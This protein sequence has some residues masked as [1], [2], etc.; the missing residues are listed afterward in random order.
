MRAPEQ[1]GR[2]RILGEL[3]R[4]AMGTVYRARDLGLEREV[5]LKVMTRGAADE[6]ARARFLREARAAA[7]LQHPNIVVIYE[8]GEHAGAPF[9]A[10][11]LLEGVDLQHAIEAGLRPD[12]RTTLPIMLQV[13]AGL[14]HAHDHG[15]VHRDIKP[16]NVF[17]P[18][19]RPAKIMDFGVARLGGTTTTTSG[20]VTG[21]PSYMSP[22]QVAGDEIDG[23]SDLFSVGLILFELVTGEKAIQAE[24]IVST[25]YK[26][27][28]E[29]PDLALLPQ[30]TEWRRLRDV[31]ARALA[32]SREQRYPDARSMSAELLQALGDFGGVPDW[33]APA[34]QALVP[35]RRRPVA[36][37]GGSASPAA[38]RPPMRP[39]TVPSG[40]KAARRWRLAGAALAALATLAAGAWWLRS[41]GVGPA[42]T[43]PSPLV[44]APPSVDAAPAS[45]SPQASSPQRPSP[46]PSA[47]AG[48]SPT[49]SASASAE[50]S[51]SPAEATEASAPSPSVP[52]GGSAEARLAR[53]RQ[54]LE[55][56][57]WAEALAEARAVLEGAPTNAEAASLAQ[58]AEAELVLEDCLRKA[59]A[60]I[61][62]GDRDRALEELRRGFL[63]RSNDPRLLELH[64]QAVQQ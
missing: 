33:T 63:V 16:S 9:M 41:P 54:A 18:V 51:A 49:S 31:L 8:L 23:R 62:A 48:P 24:S 47:D 40:P 26:V 44:P 6:A 58:L 14:A 13:L 30:G 17:L 32:R 39:P 52:G 59:R 53:A 50:T 61:Q 15:V 38:L 11:E 34:D 1:I 29:G 12:P 36:A 43:Q 10:L 45:P 57:G 2:Y 46:R 42:T 60:A 35:Q 37:L 28:H 64:R 55:R 25:L 20:A 56:K 3:G 21:T 5:A 7:K 27:L 22:E 19:S 4:G